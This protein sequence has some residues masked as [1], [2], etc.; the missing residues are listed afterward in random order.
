[1][2]KVKIDSA[3]LKR[4]MQNNAEANAQLAKDFAEFQKT[5][6]EKS[7]TDAKTIAELTERLAKAEAANEDYKT[8]IADLEELTTEDVEA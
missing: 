6:A 5:Q 2:P 7:A 1:M 4:G 3:D 8:R